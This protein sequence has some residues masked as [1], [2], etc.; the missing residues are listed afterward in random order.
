MNSFMKVFRLDILVMSFLIISCADHPDSYVI[1]ELSS[2]LIPMGSTAA[3]SFSTEILL[4]TVPFDYSVEQDGLGG[5]WAVIPLMN[6]DTVTT[7]TIRHKVMRRESAWYAGGPET[8]LSWLEENKE[9]NW[10]DKSIQA[11]TAEL[12]L[13][14]MEREDAVRRIG[15]FLKNRI[16]FDMSYSFDPAAFTA[17]ET[18]NMNKGVCIN[19]SRLFTAICRAAG[20]PS[21]TVCGIVRNHDDPSTYDF[22]HEWMEYLDT[23]G[24]W[25][26]LDL[27]YSTNYELNDPRYAGFV[28]GAED[29]PWF[30]GRKM[31]PVQLKNGNIIPYH[32]LPLFRGARYGFKLID[33]SH[34]EWYLIEKTLIVEIVGNKDIK[35]VLLK[36]LSL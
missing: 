20:I 19:Y 6:F 18:L 34:M 35:K 8:A 11:V 10:K 30:A 24:R 4:D 3:P 29:H 23:D 21:R 9:I 12:N 1:D 2:L 14:A 27:T 16:K 31:Q 15:A 36:S 13:D 17:S 32:Y 7:L 26:P 28:Y 22:H 5:A 33:S 25:H